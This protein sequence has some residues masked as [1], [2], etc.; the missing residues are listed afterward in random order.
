MQPD[1]SAHAP[2]DILVVSDQHCRAAAAAV[3]ARLSSQLARSCHECQQC[4][5]LVTVALPVVELLACHVIMTMGREHQ[6]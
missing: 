6:Q 5:E 2:P 1:A 3:D 4:H